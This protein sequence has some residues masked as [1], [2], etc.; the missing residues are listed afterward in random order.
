MRLQL[1]GRNTGSMPLHGADII[2]KY[3]HYTALAVVFIVS[4]LIFKLSGLFHD[5]FE[6]MMGVVTY[7][8]WHNL[9]ELFGALVCFSVFMVPYYT[10]GEDKNLKALFIGNVFLAAG[11]LDVFHT[12]SFKGMPE[13]LIENTG[14]NRATTLWILSRLITS[15]GL[16]IASFIG[17]ETRTRVDKRLFLGVALLVGFSS[18]AV[19]TYYPDLLPCMYIDGVG[20]SNL[21]K[22][23]EYVVMIL[24]AATL[25]RFLARYRKSKDNVEVLFCIAL[26]LNIFAEYAFISYYSVYDIY[27]YL[28]HIYKFVASFVIFRVIFIRDV[29][30]PYVEL[31]KAKDEIKAYAENLDRIVDERTRELKQM[32][33]KLIEDMEYARDIQ[34]ALLPSNLPREYEVCFDARYFPAE[35]VSGDFYNVFKLDEQHIGLYIGDV[36]GHGVPA[37]MLTVFLNQSM[38][39]IHEEGPEGVKIMSPADVLKNIYKSFNSTNFREDIYLVLLY[40]IYNRKTKE[41]VYASAGINVP[42]LVMEAG[43]K[44]NE[45]PVR[46][47]PICKFIEFYSGEYTNMK[48]QLQKGDKVLFYTD[49]LIDAE[50]SEGERFSDS[51]LKAVVESNI[52]QPDVV[53]AREI[54]QSVFGFT[55]SSQLKDD[56]TFF[57]ME[58]H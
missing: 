57:V 1:N 10:Y 46:G 37:A 3:P 15:A 39:M 14:A 17:P 13:F 33:R 4:C 7:L 38:K 6:K 26:L 53:L 18:L 49:G 23:L 48:I 51:R 31:S 24:F 58:V 22:I 54:T 32:N 29:Q 36:S 28:G 52:N 5:Q 30:K 11:I 16:F 8:S 12:L 47:F 25:G 21:K 9:F 42:P 43:G 20:L 44:V 34:K 40:G 35:R 27:N 41:F 56:V 55:G 19:A 50:N 2:K 45:L